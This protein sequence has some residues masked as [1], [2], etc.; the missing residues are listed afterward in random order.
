LK[1]PQPPPSWT[2]TPEQVLSI[3]KETIEATRELQT[4]VAN[5]PTDAR[6]FSSVFLALADAEAKIEAIIEPLAFYQNV[7]PSKE[8][9]DASNEAESLVRDFGVESSMRV[10]VFE[11]IQVAAENIEKNKEVLSSESK[12]LVEKMLLDGKRAGLALP[13]EERKVL[14]DVCVQ[15]L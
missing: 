13:E 14:T 15:Q 3:T 4:R 10:D 5:L 1:A 8:L 2:H 7:S 11:A 9:R 12:R 6:S